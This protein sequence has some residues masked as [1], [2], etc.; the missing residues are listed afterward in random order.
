MQAV[1]RTLVIS[2]LILI[3]IL[4]GGRASMAQTF[5][6]LELVLAVD[7]SGSVDHSEYILQVQGIAHAITD[8]EVV[9]AIQSGPIGRIAVAMIVW[10][11]AGI[12][13]DETPWFLIE[14]LEDAQRFAGVVASFRRRVTGGTGIGS[15]LTQGMRMFERN[16]VEA[17]RQ[18]VD[19]SGDGRE[20]PP[21]DYVAL[22]VHARGMALSRG[23]TINGLA[24]LNEDP[25]LD[26][27][28][29]EAVITGPGAF[30]MTV[31]DYPDFAEA[32]RNKLLREIENRPE[33]S[34]A[35]SE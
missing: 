27:W 24:I 12:P 17:T 29:R 30:V 26:D 22:V 20:T 19:V 28:Y 9:D 33:I 6:D 3:G 23:I 2:S 25:E 13:G 34:R 1:A 8:R 15:G 10:G 31:A 18:V 16:G 4:A 14:T 21:R 35:R 11:E 32:M 7:A 5:A